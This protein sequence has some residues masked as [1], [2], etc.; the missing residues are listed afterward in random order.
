VLVL[1]ADKATKIDGSVI[2]AIRNANHA[3]II[4]VVDECG[5][6]A[7]SDLA[8]NFSTF[9]P[10]IKIVSI[11]QDRD[12][13]DGASE[14]RL[15]SM[16]QLPS[17]EIETILKSYGVELATV[18]G[19]AELCEGSPRVAHV[20]GQNLR[21]HPDDP[22]RSDGTAQ[23]WVRF[24]AAD[25]DRGSEEYRKRH[26]VL[27]SLALFKKF[28][29]GPSVRSDAFQIYDLIISKL[30]SGVSKAQFG[31]I[32]EQMV[33]RKV[34]QGDNFLYITPRALHIRLWIDWWNQH[35]V[36][37]DMIELIPKLA[38]QV[39]Q[40]FGEMIEYAEATSVAKSLVT[41]L[42]G[43]DGLY[44]DAMWLNTREG[45]RFF[46]NLSVADPPG[47]LRT[48]QRVIGSADRDTLLQFEAGR[49][50]V[51][52]AL[53]GLALSGELFGPSAKILLKLAEA[54]NESWANNAT[55]VFAGLFSLSY[56]EAAPTSL[57]PEHRLPILTAALRDNERRA[58]I[59][60]KAFDTALTMQ[61][62][63]RL[64]NQPFRFKD[65]VSRWQ[66][67]TYGEL[68]DAIRLY[69]CA[70]RDSLKTL[71]L[72]LRLSGI[73][74]LLDRTRSLLQVEAIQDEIL[75]TIQ[76]ISILPDVDSREI[77]STV[78]MVL[79]YDKTALPEVV[80][81]KLRALLSNLVGDSFHSRLRRYAGLELFEDQYDRNGNQTNRIASDIRRLA[82]EALTSPASLSAEL[83]WLVTDEAKNGYLFGKALG[84][85]DT[86]R[87]AWS[88]ILGAYFA[89]GDRA[90]DYFIGGYLTAV[91]EREPESWERI[92]IDLAA[93]DQNLQ[94]LPRLVWRSGMSDAVAGLISRLVRDGKL[95]P[96]SL[97][98]FSTGRTSAPLTNE[99]FA[100]WLDILV[101]IGSFPASAAALNLASMSILGGRTLT[102]EQLERV[103]IQ[104]PL[105]KN[106]RAQSNTML[107]HHWLQIS[108]TLI[109]I[110]P[111][112]ELIVLRCVIENMGNSGAVTASLGPDGDRYFDELV[113]RNPAET[114]RIVSEYIVPPIDIRGFTITRWLRGGMGFNG[115]DP[116][117]MRHIPR[118]DVWSWIEL[119]PEVRAAYVASMA[120]KDFT[121]ESWSGS[122][123]RDILCGFGDSEKVQS[124]VFANFYTGGWTGPA[125]SHYESQK[126]VLEQ[127]RLNET[128]PNALRW[129]NVAI[130]SNDQNLENA[131]IREEASG[132]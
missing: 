23:I 103:L 36:S 38:P 101:S 110:K 48:L 31:Q 131:R 111:E 68:F 126:Q 5:P 19:W 32:I 8:R 119:D 108:R 35:G 82:E 43:P 91:F 17:P 66:P 20:I 92:I 18:A 120:P 81:S 73:H 125:S 99:R 118:E 13:A 122:L 128:H 57:A 71:P 22:L 62:L 33:L 37:L 44:A 132:Y 28:G 93:I 50:D 114:W 49:R 54:E 90:H 76:E 53:E 95:A 26:L 87:Q 100:E 7:R 86:Q 74:I 55:G 109:G 29:W 84:Q 12:E 15:L 105:F 11:Y 69:W 83:G 16:P 14:Y 94:L 107:S 61:S 106:E 80:I 56:G 40:W 113:S 116:G 117:P 104:P 129:L 127:I 51:I 34:L 2:S 39:R 42:L 79:S 124:A 45:G 121:V 4:L 97:G 115:S 46:F 24:L 75:N 63:G 41:R 52:W 21:D 64:G 112:A 72:E 25:V 59:A 85:F 30:D 60:L 6:D 123:V 88:D 67:K 3:R 70:L 96:E 27:S 98:I 65:Q 9:G 102:S 47:A 1:Y 58:R 10:T 89:A 130:E 78:E 77:I